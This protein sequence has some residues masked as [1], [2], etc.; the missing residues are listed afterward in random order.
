MRFPC[1]LALA[2][3]AIAFTSGCNTGE[4]KAVVPISGGGKITVPLTKEGPAPG[5]AEG[6]RIE[7]AALQ[8]GKQANEAFYGFGLV[9][10]HEPAL[11][12][13]QIE[14]ISDEKAVTLIDEKDPKFVNRRWVASTEPITAEDP[15]LKWVMQITLSMRVYHV[16]LTLAD[17]RTAAF[18]HVTTYP[19][20][21]KAAIRAKLGLNY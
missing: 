13:I 7:V 16:T 4:V 11:Q 17:G 5:E 9:A 18:N 21:I 8:P 14:D 6:Y 3:G 15:R 10:A 2:L 20:F 19:P 12:R 1:L